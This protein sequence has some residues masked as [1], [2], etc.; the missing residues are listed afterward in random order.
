MSA[1]ATLCY[2][3]YNRPQFVRES[4]ITGVEGAGYP[5]EVLVHDDGSDPGTLDAVLELRD[6]GLIS[7]LIINQWGHNEGQGI[8][9][10]RMFAMAKGDP[11]CKLD[12]DLIFAEG[13]LAKAIELLNANKERASEPRIGTLGLF[14]YFQEPVHRDQ[15]F[16]AHHGTGRT[17]WE[18]H[19]DF[20]G[21]AMVIPRDAWE[22]FG[23]FQER[24]EAFAEDHDWKMRV[25][26]TEGWANALPPETLAQNQGFGLGPS[27]VVVQTPDGSLTSRAIKPEPFVV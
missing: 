7:T 2:L 5:V 8:A 26:E 17:A 4:I 14:P 3:S 19:A 25:T 13:W 18:E 20:V 10:N 9:L 22:R 24:S 23:P 21:S 16:V 27:T 1:F 6:Q 11:I 15:M 12:H